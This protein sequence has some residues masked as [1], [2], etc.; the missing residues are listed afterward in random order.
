MQ[1]CSVDKRHSQLQIPH[2][3]H[4]GALLTVTAVALF[5]ALLTAT[6]VALLSAT[7]VALW[8]CL[9]STLPAS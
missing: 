2:L 4:A 8:R 7:A 1:H 9:T 6:A 3:L 5:T